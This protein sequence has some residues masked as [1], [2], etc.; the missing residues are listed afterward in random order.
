MSG[1]TL[2]FRV[3]GYEVSA[4]FAGTPNR[5]ITH[6][7]KQILMASFVNNTSVLPLATSLQ[8]SQ[9]GDTI[10][11]VIITVHL[12][13]CIEFVWMHLPFDCINQ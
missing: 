1:R 12:E 9:N 4:S 3:D 11:T 10:K 8:R 6:H 2:S 5:T 7:L 13:N